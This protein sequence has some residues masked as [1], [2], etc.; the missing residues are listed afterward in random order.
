M[1][2]EIKTA[3]DAMTPIIFSVFIFDP[4]IPLNTKPSN[5]SQIAKNK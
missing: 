5:G 4:N 1:A 2:K 3:P